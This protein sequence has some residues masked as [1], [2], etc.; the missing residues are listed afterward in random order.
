MVTIEKSKAKVISTGNRPVPGDRKKL[1]ESWA[2]IPTVAIAQ[3]IVA[4]RDAYVLEVLPAARNRSAD[5]ILY[6]VEIDNGRHR[7]GYSIVDEEGR[8]S[9]LGIGAYVCVALIS[10][11]PKK[12]EKGHF[13]VA[14]YMKQEK[15]LL[16][17][18]E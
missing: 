2:E 5:L 8:V 16:R 12:E 10:A 4:R 15:L 17:L 11:I 3:E 18:E 14:Y 13:H 1:I 9:I 7:V 6:D